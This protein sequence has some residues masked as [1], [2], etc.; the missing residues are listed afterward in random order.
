MGLKLLGLWILKWKPHNIHIQLILST[1]GLKWDPVTRTKA[2]PTNL[3]RLHSACG[4]IKQQP[5]SYRPVQ[6]NPHNCQYHNIAQLL[7]P[8]NL[9]TF[10]FLLIQTSYPTRQLSTYIHLCRFTDCLVGWSSS[11]SVYYINNL[12]SSMCLAFQTLF[13]SAVVHNSLWPHHLICRRTLH[14]GTPSFEVH[15]IRHIPH[16]SIHTIV[17]TSPH[18]RCLKFFSTV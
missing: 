1:S 15:L 10:Q 13:L 6:S 2:L 9:K 5:V 7:I 17:I 14:T 4:S 8:G 11:H 16:I 12:V 18:C 3:T